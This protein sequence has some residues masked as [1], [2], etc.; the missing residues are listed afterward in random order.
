MFSPS[1]SIQYSAAINGTVSGALTQKVYHGCCGSKITATANYGFEF[2][3]WSDGR[4]DNPREDCRVTNDINVTA[5]FSPAKPSDFS[6][7]DGS[8]L[9]AV[10]LNWTPAPLATAYRIFRAANSSNIGSATFLATCTSTDYYDYSVGYE[11]NYY[12]WLQAVSPGYTSAVTYS[13]IGFPAKYGPMIIINNMVGYS[14]CFNKDTPMNAAIQMLVPSSYL[15]IPVDWWAVAFAG[16]AN[17]WYYLNSY[18]QWCPFDGQLEYEHIVPAYMGNLF[19][20]IPPL[21]ITSNFILPPDIY[22]IWVAVDYPMD[23]KP[24]PLYLVIDGASFRIK[25]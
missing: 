7:S 15:G 3:Q 13:D 16:Y 1:Y 2:L 24:E 23:G 4:T 21:T 11:T 18:F 8:V 9:D 12:Y 25:N 20:I 14:L 22:Y 6:A 17:Q 10:Y 19:N 5:I